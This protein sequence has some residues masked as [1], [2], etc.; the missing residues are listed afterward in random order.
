MTHVDVVPTH[1]DEGI[2]LVEAL[3]TTSREDAGNSRFDA[4]QQAGRPNHMSLVETWRDHT[5]AEAH[6]LAAHVRRF[7]EQLSPLSGALYDERRY[8]SIN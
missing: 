5:A 8:R 4:H 7:R 3:Y 1:K 2:V 6:A